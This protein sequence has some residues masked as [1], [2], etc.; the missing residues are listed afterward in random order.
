MTEKDWLVYQ[1]PEILSS[2]KPGSVAF[3][4]FLRT[5]SMSCAVYHVPAGSSDM[6][7]AHEE[8]ELYFI[9]D[10][11]GRLRIGDKEHVVAKGTLMYVCASSDHTF[12]D[13]EQDITA[14]AFFGTVCKRC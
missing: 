5:P 8:D 13:V 12:F 1:L 14:L 4:E 11:R 10:G 6:Q 7:S 3:K 9:V 2:I